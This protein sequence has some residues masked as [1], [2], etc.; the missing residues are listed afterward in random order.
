MCRPHR[1]T[2]KTEGDIME[3]L[4]QDNTSVDTTLAGIIDSQEPI[5]GGKIHTFEEFQSEIRAKDDYF[6]ACANL[7]IINILK[8]SVDKNE[9]I[10]M[11]E[12]I[13]LMGIAMEQHTRAEAKVISTAIDAVSSEHVQGISEAI[14]EL[15]DEEDSKEEV[16]QTVTDTIKEDN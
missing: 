5:D 13:M 1:A 9:L 15:R 16:T 14:R 8:Q 2:T 7:E 6:L 3:L 4:E 12:F 10:P 11:P